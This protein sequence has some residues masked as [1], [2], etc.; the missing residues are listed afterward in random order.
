[1]RSVGDMVSPF[2][3][4]R[5]YYLVGT[6]QP[7]HLPTFNISRQRVDALI[8]VWVQQQETKTTSRFLPSVPIPKEPRQLVLTK[9]Q[10]FLLHRD[11]W[12]S[13]RIGSRKLAPDTPT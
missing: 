11:Q 10:H 5:G 1:M 2:A 3:P 6:T 12:F 9:L 4:T 13:V 7:W 8:G